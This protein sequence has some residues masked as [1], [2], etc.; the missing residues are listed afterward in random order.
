MN[1]IRLECTTGGHNKFYEFHGI[2][3]N[4]RFTMKGLFGAIGQAPKVVIIYDGDNKA[5]ANNEFQRKLNEK[6]RKGYVVVT[7][8]GASVPAPAEKKTILFP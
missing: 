4:G 1:I 8:N 6:K 7:Q 2:Q 5:E 3:N